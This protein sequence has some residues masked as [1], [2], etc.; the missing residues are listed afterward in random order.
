[1]LRAALD[2]LLAQ[3]RR[4]WEDQKVPA[5]LI[6]AAV[7]A[8]VGAP[9]WFIAPRVEMMT[10]DFR[11]RVRELLGRSPSWSQE[12]VIVAIDE[13]SAREL[14]MKVPT[15]RDYLAELIDR[16]SAYRPKVIA[17]DFLLDQRT[18]SAADKKLAES[19]RRAGNVVCPT[20]TETEDRKLCCRFTAKQQR[21]LA[22]PMSHPTQMLSFG[23]C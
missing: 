5:L 10:V 17:L 8:V 14:P 12:L 23:G 2:A 20:S 3:M 1:M 11:F 16:I 15:P 9:W 13:A 21:L 19:I 18:D 6:T 4:W 22:S 7:V